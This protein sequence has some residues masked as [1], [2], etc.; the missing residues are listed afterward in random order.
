[1]KNEQMQPLENFKRDYCK[2][3]NITEQ[4]FSEATEIDLMAKISACE[5]TRQT[6]FHVTR[7]LMKYDNQILKG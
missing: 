4:E 7:H 6:I 5:E 2:A 3:A 1:M